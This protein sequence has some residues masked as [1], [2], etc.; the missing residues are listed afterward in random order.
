MAIQWFPGH[1]NS[2]RKHA[3]DALARIDV[4]I[5]VIDARLPEASANPMIDELRKHRQRPCLKV[6]N[7]TDLAD[8]AATQAWLAWYDRQPG[9]KAVAISA[10]KPADVAKLTG[11]CR[12]LAPHRSDNTKPLRMMIMGIPN[13]GKSTIMN[14]LLKRRVAAVGDE[15]AVTKSQ[16][17]LDLG[18]GMTLT[19]TPGLMWP[20]IEHDSDGYMLAVGHAIGRN[21]VIEE[22]VAEFL[23]GILLARYPERLAERYGIKTE[24]CDGHAVVEAVARRRGCILK[25]KGGSG[26]D[27]EKAAIILLTDF[28]AGALGRISL[29]TPDTRAAMLAAAREVVV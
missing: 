13:V 17:C 3:A 1:M 23:A 24:G 2:A 28:R 7:K 10:K 25:G 26:L 12:Q 27:L 15:P 18:P 21:A 6:L 20:K 19:D 8:P 9:V 14:A 22:E 29:E 11:L 16:Q 4:V 5:E